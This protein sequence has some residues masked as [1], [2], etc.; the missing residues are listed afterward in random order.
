MSWNELKNNVEKWAEERGIYE[1]STPEAQLLKAL[2]E[3]GELADA[4]VKNDRD[5]IKDAIGDVAVCIV[6]YTR[7]AGHQFND[8]ESLLEMLHVEQKKDLDQKKSIHYCIGSAARVIGSILNGNSDDHEDA[9]LACLLTMF[10]AAHYLDIDFIDCCK[11]AWN[12]IKDRK[13]RMVEGGAFVKED[14]LQEAF[15][16]LQPE[17]V[18]RDKQGFWTHSV[19]EKEHGQSDLTPN[20][21]FE[22]R[23]IELQELFF[24]HDAPQELLYRYDIG[25]NYALLCPL[26]IP[27]KPEGENWFILSIHDTEDSG[28]VCWWARQKDKK[29]RRNT[30]RNRC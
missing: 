1:H 11:S 28:P 18:R 2:S 10:F 3:L 30:F 5:A 8:V 24:E 13:G 14:D 21:W 23:G 4:V 26:W 22:S 12:E 7:I 9:S 19:L 15:N 17:E 25:E 6:N 27:T 29:T 16:Q 20:S